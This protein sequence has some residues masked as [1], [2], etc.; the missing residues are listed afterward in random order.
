[1]TPF[2][3]QMSSRSEKTRR[4]PPPLF[5]QLFLSN[6][7]LLVV[8]VLTL[9][10][11]PATVSQPVSVEE[12]A[13]LVGG[14]AAMLV[15][16]L[17]LIRHAVGPLEKLTRLMYAVDPLYPGT[18]ETR[19]QGSAET[20]ELA[21]VFNEMA[22]RLEDERQQSS[23]RMLLAQENER[24][25]LAQELHDEIGQSLTG[26]MLEIDRVARA[27]PPEIRPELDE[28]REAA[29]SLSDQVRDVVRGLRPEGLDDLGLVSALIALCER[30]SESTGIRVVRDTHVDG[31]RIEPDAA[32]VIYRVAQ[33][34]LTN[35]AR[36]AGASEVTVELSH[37]NGDLSLRVRDDGCGINE[38]TPGYGIQG[39]QE[40]ALLVDGRLTFRPASASGGLQVR[41][42]VPRQVG[43]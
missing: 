20:V 7:A 26:L 5:W 14:V 8:A 10:L 1:V 23:R 4:R 38:L 40:R 29:R 37:E 39:M 33:E 41:L 2:V 6:A 21:D 34:S 11:S 22:E 25:R 24:R 28:A 16:N 43:S 15:M 27:A 18:R 13:V 30:F 12:A 3:E 19:P 31:S 32:L 35:V 42:E 17:L 36:H 9:A